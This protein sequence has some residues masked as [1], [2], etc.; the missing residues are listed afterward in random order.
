MFGKAEIA[1]D[2]QQTSIV[3]PYS[4][5]VEADGKKAF[6]FTAISNNKVKKIPVNIEKFD[7]D[8]VYLTG[9]LEGA[10]NIVVSNSA[11]LNE[12]SIIKIIK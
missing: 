11:Y 3:I 5:L 7:N 4:S 8:K 10:N 6:V 9:Q 2:Q 12:Q 1:T